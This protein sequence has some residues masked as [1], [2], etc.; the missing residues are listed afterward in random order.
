MTSTGQETAR[1]RT[2][3]IIA[4]WLAQS[5]SVSGTRATHTA[6]S[7]RPRAPE[8]VDPPGFAR[9]RPETT[10]LYQLVEQHYR[11]FREQRAMS[12]RP[13]PAC[14]QEEFDAYPQCGRLEE[15]SCA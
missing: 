10:L 1:R 15:G 11:A 13:S 2:F 8:F 12:G 7:A 4:T 14:V 9:H 6:A 5:L 3:A